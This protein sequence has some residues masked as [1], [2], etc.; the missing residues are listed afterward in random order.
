MNQICF[1]TGNKNKL[2]EV[3]NLLTNY[4][5]VSLDDLNFSEDIAETENTIQGNAEL[6][7]SFINNKYNI[8]CFS[9][10]TGL[11]IDSLG[12]L[13]GVK[14]ARYAGENC[15]SEENIALVLKNLKDKSDRNASFKT[16]ICLIQNNSTYFF[17]G[18]I[19]GKITEEKVG[20]SGFGYDPIFIPDGFDKTFSELTIN[21][22]N[23]ISHRGIAVNKLVNFLNGK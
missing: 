6:K 11:F 14:S 21:E 23:A 22:K 12:G 8:D 19:N 17:E 16:V 4:K 5:I 13:P 10:D 7:A 1:V 3:Q 2:R 20:H 15:N 9:D 18:V